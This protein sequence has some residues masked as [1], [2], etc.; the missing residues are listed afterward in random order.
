MNTHTTGRR[1]AKSACVL[2]V[3]L[4][5]ATAP[6]FAQ[7]EADFTVTLTDDGAGVVIT[8]YTGKV[9][10]VK[11]PAM[12]QGMPVK[13]I[14]K[15]DIWESPEGPF[16]GSNITGVIIPPGVTHIGRNAFMN[17]GKLT[18]VTLPDGLTNI[19]DNAFS[20]CTSLQ[21]I[22]LPDSVTALGSSYGGRAFASSGLRSIKLSK[23]LTTIEQQTFKECERLTGVVI[24]EGVITIGGEAFL[25]CTALASLTLPSTIKQIEP[26]AFNT[27]SSLA[28][29]TI[30]DSVGSIY[31]GEGA[32]SV[33]PKLPL[34][35]QAALRKRG[36][37][38]GF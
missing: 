24:P 6:A 23:G 16:Q 10:S 14:G 19:G 29:V 18:Q 13:Q 37:T 3:L 17:C 31:I 38:D 32:F 1:N 26:L 25:L 4:A 34:A 30:P 20:Y 11:I 8:G 27:C 12:I 35:A 15:E 22:T 21:T 33:C 9:M 36:Y 7:S 5:A 2:A 28:G